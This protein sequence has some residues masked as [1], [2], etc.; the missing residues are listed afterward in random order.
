MKTLRSI[1]ALFLLLVSVTGCS[2]PPDPPEVAK[3]REQELLLWRAG[4]QIFM[5]AE[6]D[7]YSAMLKQAYEAFLKEQA[8]IALFINYEDVVAEYSRVIGYGDNLK[9]QLDALKQGKT[10]AL[11][12]QIQGHE[13]RL[14]KL[15]QA[16]ELI[17]E[18]RLAR[19]SLTQAELMLANVSGLL[20]KGDILAAEKKIGAIPPHL[21]R[22]EH[23]LAPIINRYTDAGQI[24]KWRSWVDDTLADSASRRSTAIVVNKIKKTMH[25]YRAGNLVRTY[26]VEL[27]LNGAKDKMYAG[28]KATPE[29]KYRIIKKKPN[30]KFYKALLINYPNEEDV[31]AYNLA[32]KKGLVPKKAGIGSLIEIHGGGDDSLTLGCVSM[33]NN[34]IDE[35][36]NMVEVGT[37][38]TIVGAMSNDNLF[39]VTL[40]KR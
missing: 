15:R 7:K 22:A 30:S 13:E 26:P 9:G 24:R 19:K 21:E 3:A 34:H 18:G 20:K 37:P 4:A 40:A 1:F 33:E 5:Q 25:V 23:A 27:G 12:Q 39:S 2:T 10:A 16:S 31:K 6:Y 17:N 14:R 38:V 8:Q 36:Y 35:L 11:Q 32:K 29:G 28:D